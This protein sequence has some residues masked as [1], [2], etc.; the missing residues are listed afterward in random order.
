MIFYDKSPDIAAVKPDCYR[1]YAKRGISAQLM[2]VSVQAEQN[3]REK[4]G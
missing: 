1:G 3:L 4:D 2:V